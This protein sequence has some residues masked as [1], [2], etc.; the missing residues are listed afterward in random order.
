MQQ[1]DQEACESIWEWGQIICVRMAISQAGEDGGY[2][3]RWQVTEVVAV[4]RQ[5]SLL[6]LAW[7]L[8]GWLAGWAFVKAPGWVYKCN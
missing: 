4:A 7:S 3:I 1:Q 6:H 5:Q 2:Q 8:L